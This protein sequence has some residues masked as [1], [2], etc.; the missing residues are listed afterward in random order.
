MPSMRMMIVEEE[1]DDD[2]ADEEGRKGVT[3]ATRQNCH[4]MLYH[5]H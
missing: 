5:L 3:V 4:T 1:G 2:V